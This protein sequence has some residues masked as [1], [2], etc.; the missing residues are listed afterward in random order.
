MGIFDENK[1]ADVLSE[2]AV[3]AVHDQA[4]RRARERIDTL[5]YQPP[6]LRDFVRKLMPESETARILIFYS[7]L[8]DLIRNLIVLHMTR[9]DGEHDRERMFGTYGP[10]ST[11][12]SRLLMAYHL[13]WLSKAVKERLDAFR[14]VRNAFAERAFAVSMDDP[15][16]VKDLALLDYDIQHFMRDA[17]GSEGYDFSQA[18]SALCR[19]IMLAFEA[20]RDLLVLPIASALQVSPDW[21]SPNFDD[22]PEL[23]KAMD[24]AMTAGL[25]EAGAVKRLVG[26]N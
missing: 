17:F 13:G 19:L 14:R 20:S 16:V 9:L 23:L 3:R 6:P 15:G 25:I 1:V 18:N 11:F 7:Y 2:R 4:I 5:V 26:V 10:L 21:I 22:Q 8:D 12:G 24:R